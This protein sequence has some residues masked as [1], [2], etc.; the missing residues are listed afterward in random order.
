[1]T[2]VFQYGSNMS[3]R[4]L[5]GEDRLRGDA[6]VK[7][8]AQ[9][10]EPF[11]LLFS[12]WSKGNNCA[13]A[14]IFQSRAGRRLFGVVYEI[15]DHLLSRETAKSHDRMS[16]DAIE[17]EGRNYVRQAIE[18]E[19]LDGYRFTAMTYVAETRRVGIKTQMHYVQHIFDGVR[20]HNLPMEY[21]EYASGQITTN[22]P[23]LTAYLSAQLRNV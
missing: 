5:N 17:G 14:D 8:V 6:K 3:S 2:L 16:M 19:E 15:P 9:T 23:A 1:M 7:C 10:V 12:V 11:E 22:N 18:L 20:E 13:A 21:L 4:R